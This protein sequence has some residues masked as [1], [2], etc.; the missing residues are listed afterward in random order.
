MG[1]YT[2]NAA[3][4][5]VPSELFLSTHLPTLEGYFICSF[6]WCGNINSASQQM[7][8]LVTSLKLKSSLN[9]SIFLQ[10]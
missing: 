6:K 4:L 5:L 2:A 3:F 8:D 7:I 1:S 9:L 10:I